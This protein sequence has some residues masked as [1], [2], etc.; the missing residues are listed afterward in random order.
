MG[1]IQKV[2]TGGAKSDRKMELHE[3][4]MWNLIRSKHKED[5]FI[6]YACVYLFTYSQRADS[7]CRVY[8]KGVLHFACS[9]DLA[10][11][12]LSSQVHRER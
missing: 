1:K 12:L 7:G 6:I 9:H 4:L 10:C 3:A 8:V 11:L 2:M 5:V